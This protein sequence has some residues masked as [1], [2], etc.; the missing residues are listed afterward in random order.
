M[1][2]ANG[3]FISG[4]FVANTLGSSGLPANV[5]GDG[6]VDI[7]DFANF[8]A[9]FSGEGVLANDACQLSFD[10]DCDG[11]IDLADLTVFQEA[12]NGPLP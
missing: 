5:D 10:Y 11:D 7:I 2:D 4:L 9:C 3:N 12:L 6:D 1:D 8:Q